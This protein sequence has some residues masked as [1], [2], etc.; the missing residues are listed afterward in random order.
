M[1]KT[2]PQIGFP[3]REHRG[4]II[5]IEPL[6]VCLAEL[7]PLHIAQ[8]NEIEE[9]RPPFNPDYQRFIDSES[10]GQFFQVTVRKNDEL[11]GGIGFFVFPSVWTQRWIA[12]E[13]A[14]YLK[15]EHRKGLL[16]S[17]VCIY[18][19][20]VLRAL[21]VSELEVTVKSY[22][23]TGVILRRQKFRQTDTV[24]LKNLE[25]ENVQ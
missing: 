24:W 19:E 7:K 22:A 25:V 3:T 11:V 20:K 14:F 13:T 2:I 16:A 12:E 18:S 9:Q 21:G 8:W 1:T 17:T 6:S 4:Y 15:P 5:A 23:N 10:S